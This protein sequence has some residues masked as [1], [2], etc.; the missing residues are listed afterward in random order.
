MDTFTPPY[1]PKTSTPTYKAIGSDNTFGD[2]YEQ[3]IRT[4]LHNYKIDSLSLSWDILTLAQMQ[5]I[6]EFFKAHV[7]ITFLWKLAHET[8]PRMWRID[9]W[10]PPMSAG[11]ASI[12]ANFHEVFA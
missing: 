5:A 3:G 9:E 7:K 6:D 4:D 1:R 10:S 12:T 11:Q 2:G 8:T